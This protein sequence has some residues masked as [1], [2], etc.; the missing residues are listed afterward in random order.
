MNGVEKMD[1]VYIVSSKRRIKRLEMKQAGARFSLKKV[2][3]IQ[4][5]VKLWK[6]LQLDVMNVNTSKN[7]K[8]K[9]EK[10]MEENSI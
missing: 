3:F 1:R 9:M 4:L 10:V 2:V 8:G 5:G 7:F 6:C